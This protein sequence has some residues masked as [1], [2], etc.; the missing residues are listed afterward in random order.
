MSYDNVEPRVPSQTKAWIT[1]LQFGL[2]GFVLLGFI[3]MILCCA[4]SIFAPRMLGTPSTESLAQ[5]YLDAIIHG[6]IGAAAALAHAGDQIC[7]N[8]MQQSVQRDIQLLNGAEVRNVQ[9]TVRPGEGSSKSVEF[10]T[11]SFEF[12]L[13]PQMAWKIG[14]LHLTTDH[15]RNYLG[16]PRYACGF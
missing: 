15:D 1:G 10:A 5:S 13:S 11:I 6:N 9:I 4:V 2:V 7:K 14:E 8:L 12:R 16:T 3:Y